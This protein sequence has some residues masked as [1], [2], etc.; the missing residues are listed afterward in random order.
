MA[1]T[2]ITPNEQPHV[3]RQRPDRSVDEFHEGCGQGRP[4][5]A[6]GE[7]G[8]VEELARQISGQATGPW[9]RQTECL[10]A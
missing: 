6:C 1:R 3:D 2:K 7:S 9:G 5:R 8:D 10:T 4:V